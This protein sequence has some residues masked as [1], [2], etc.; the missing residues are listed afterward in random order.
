MLSPVDTQRS[1]VSLIDAIHMQTEGAFFRDELVSSRAQAG[2]RAD[3]SD[4]V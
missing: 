2:K 1:G 4:D 3:D